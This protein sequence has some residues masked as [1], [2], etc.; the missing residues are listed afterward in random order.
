MW[1]KQYNSKQS[2]HLS[3]SIEVNGFRRVA[4][5]GIVSYSEHTTKFY[6][7]QNDEYHMRNMLNLV[8]KYTD[9][10]IKI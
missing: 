3:K 4:Q 5:D 2:L 8:S 1:L 7:S 6:Y 10:I 9:P